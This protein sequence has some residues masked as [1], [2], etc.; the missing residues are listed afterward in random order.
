[1]P[2]LLSTV[3]TRHPRYSVALVFLV[4]LT[5]FFLIPHS[6]YNYVDA[7]EYFQTRSSTRWLANLL[8]QQEQSY[9]EHLERREG[10]VRKFGPTA[11]DVESFPDSQ[12]L[13]TLWDFFIPAF[14]CPHRVE[15]VG[16]LGDGGKWMCGMDRVARQ[17]DCVIYSFGLNG[18]VSF[19]AELLQRA[20]GCQIWGYDYSVQSIGP[21]IEN[22]I[23]RNNASLA[24]RAHFHAYALGGTDAHTSNPPTHTLKSILQENGHTFID[25]L[26]IDVESWEFEA[27]ENF[28][29]EYIESG[30][31]LPVGQMQIEIHATVSSGYSR[32]AK[33]KAWWEKLEAVGLR[34]FW[35][36]PNMVYLN[37]IRG[38]RP[39]LTEVGSFLSVMLL[40]HPC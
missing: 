40:L 8:A 31:V 9:K 21:D 6:T 13:Y 33:F 7:S 19:E 14:Q 38:A 30:E 17:K 34:P 37:I 11:E 23:D 12:K 18:E 24:S 3:I 16:N 5:T 39:D 10:L 29:K 20:P 27:L 25:I 1:M 28:V 26:K 32:F 35:T 2:P 15:R 4:V 36:E 22:G